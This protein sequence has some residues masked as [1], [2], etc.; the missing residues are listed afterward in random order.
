MGFQA[1]QTN[2]SFPFILSGVAFIKDA[3]TIL[4]I[5]GRTVALAQYTVMSQIASSGKWAPWLNAN[6]GGT[7]GT[8]YPMGILMTDGGLTAAALAAG[9][10]TNVQIMVGGKGCEIDSSQL[11]FDKGDGGLGTAGALTNIPTV[12][13]NLALT[14]ET[15]LQMKGIFCGTTVAADNLE[16]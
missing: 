6:L 11:V 12:P 14:A 4:Q 2:N 15:I 7:T 10:V 1:S 13:T 5:A 9:D 3:E 16:N 8:Q